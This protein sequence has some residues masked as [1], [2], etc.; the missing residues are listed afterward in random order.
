MGGRKTKTEPIVGRP[1]PQ[2]GGGSSNNCSTYN[3]WGGWG[4]ERMNNIYAIATKSCLTV[5]ILAQVI[6]L[7]LFS[8]PPTSYLLFVS[9]MVSRVLLIALRN[10]AM[11]V[12]MDLYPF[13]CVKT[14]RYRH[15]ES[16][17]QRSYLDPEILSS[18]PPW[19][20][21]VLAA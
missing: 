9:R 1:T 13:D 10:P 12:E 11:T 2:R 3:G 19:I 5:A 18:G 16:L 21:S 20:C 8:H 7:K 6:L 15:K 17:L 14:A 4:E